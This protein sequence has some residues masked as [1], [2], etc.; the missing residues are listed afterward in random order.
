MA[1]R[2]KQPS[3]MSYAGR[4][5]VLSRDTP[6]S[7]RYTRPVHTP[8]DHARCPY[9]S[10]Q[11]KDQGKSEAKRREESGR[12]SLMVK[13]HRPFPELRPKHEQGQVRSAFNQ[14]WF[15]EQRAAQLKFLKAQ[16]KVVQ[17]ENQRSEPV[18]ER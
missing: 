8:F 2:G 11:L 13:L 3:R 5:P 4:D 10:R 18:R 16:R 6:D 9:I 1:G 15:R 17:H 12:G 7:L 14:A